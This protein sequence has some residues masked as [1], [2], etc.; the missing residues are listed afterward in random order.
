[1]LRRTSAAKHGRR[2]V[3]PSTTNSS[4]S[5]CAST[6]ESSSQDSCSTNLEHPSTSEASVPRPRNLEPPPRQGT[7]GRVVSEYTDR[8]DFRSTVN[9]RR[10]RSESTPP[11]PSPWA[12]AQ[13]EPPN[14]TG[15]SVS[16]RRASVD[17]PRTPSFESAP[18]LDTVKSKR[19]S[20]LNRK[21]VRKAP[22]A[23]SG[24]S[25]NHAS[26]P[27]LPPL[28]LSVERRKPQ[29]FGP[30][31]HRRRSQNAP[32]T[33]PVKRR[34]M[35]FDARHSMTLLSPSTD[36]EPCCSE[37]HPPDTVHDCRMSPKRSQTLRTQPYEAPYFFPIPGS[38]E[39]GNYLPPRRK[40]VRSR[41]LPAEEHSSR[42]M[43]APED[44][45][46]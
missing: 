17:L 14:A 27:P 6:S 31:L 18:S 30:F 15:G 24:L 12:S 32:G 20:F 8:P 13:P 28:P 19:L 23:P 16:S 34:S 41:T 29:L 33:D 35:T 3:N 40:P 38:V 42:L 10:R 25:A 7:H 11:S 44:L 2:K 1:M 5:S 21:K 43:S 46:R 9:H 26:P 4:I 45:Q 39:A 22:S 37:G 36:E